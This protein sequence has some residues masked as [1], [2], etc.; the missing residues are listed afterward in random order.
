MDSGGDVSGDISRY[1]S[2]DSG[3]DISGCR[4]NNHYKKNKGNKSNMRK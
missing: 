3:G 1:S 2:M 4:N